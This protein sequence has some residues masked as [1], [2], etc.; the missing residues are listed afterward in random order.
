VVHRRLA[1]QQQDVRAYPQY[2]FHHE[3]AKPTAS[4]RFSFPISLP[5]GL[6]QGQ[7]TDRLALRR[8]LDSQRGGLEAAALVERFDRDRQNAI[9]LLSDPR[10]QAA[11]DVSAADEKTQ[12]R[13]GKNSFGWSLLMARQLVEAG[14]ALVQ[15]NLGNNESWDTHQ[16]AFPN[17]KNFLL[18]PTA[19]SP[20]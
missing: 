7:F 9:S 15:V 10:T 17:L 13:F 20:H 1:V 18:P 19:A 11:F 14:V 12:D 16:S 5:Q 2:E 4:C 3:M 8:L 6:T